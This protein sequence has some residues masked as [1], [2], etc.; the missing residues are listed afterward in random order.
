MYR[1]Y[2]ITCSRLQKSKNKTRDT[3][4]VLGLQR[5]LVLS[6]SRCIPDTQR[7]QPEIPEFK[8]EE[9]PLQGQAK[10]T[11]SSKTLNSSMFYRRKVFTGKIWGEGGRVCDFL[12]I[13][14]W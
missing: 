12:L 5:Q 11:V 4:Y 10:R 6:N 8:A 2:R 7:G 1:A 9:G 13:G 14:W 3:D